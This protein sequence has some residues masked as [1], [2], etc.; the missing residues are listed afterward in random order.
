MRQSVRRWRLQQRSRR[1]RLLLGRERERRHEL[2]RFGRHVP[3][4]VTLEV[5][6][7]LVGP[8]V[9]QSG[10]RS[11]KQNDRIQWAGPF[12]LF[13]LGKK[14][15]CP[16]RIGKKLGEG[17]GPRIR[18]GWQIGVDDQRLGRIERHRGSDW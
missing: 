16:G 4:A 12:R 3:L 14:A 2:I 1:N 6:L 7:R 8:A 15:F 18:I 9:E 5:K 10:H 17:L 13:R 11:L